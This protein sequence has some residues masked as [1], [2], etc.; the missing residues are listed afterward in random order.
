MLLSPQTSIKVLGFSN[1][2]A[3]TLVKNGVETV[4]DLSNLTVDDLFEMQWMG[5]AG[6]AEI[7]K[8]FQWL[9]EGGETVRSYGF[10]EYWKEIQNDDRDFR[11]LVD[12]YN[13]EDLTLKDLSDRYQISRE[14]VRQI[15]MRGT[16]RLCEAFGNG[17]IDNAIVKTLAEYADNRVEIHMINISDDVFTGAGIAHLVSAFKPSLYKVCRNANV[18]GEWFV[19]TED[20]L[21]ELLDVIFEELRHRSTPLLLSEVEEM[22]SIDSNIIMSIKGIIEK[23]GYITHEKNKVVTGVDR[24]SIIEGYLEKIGRPASISEIVENTILKEGQVRGAL[25]NKSNYVN[26]GKSTYDL[27]WRDYSELSVVDLAMNILTAEGRAL[28]IDVII[29]YICRYKT[30]GEQNIVIELLD[31]PNFYRHD[32]YLLIKGW[33]LDK[34]EKKEHG[35]YFVALEDAVLDIINN[36]DELFDFEKIVDELSKYEDGVVS[37]NPSSIKATLVRLADKSLITRV[38]GARTGCYVR[39]G[40]TSNTGVPG[41]AAIRAKVTLGTFLNANIGKQIEIRYKTKRISSDKYWRTISVR[42]QDAKYVF[43]N[44]L[45]SYGYRIKYLKDRIIE[46]RELSN[47][48]PEKADISLDK[49]DSL[50]DM[51]TSDELI[52]DKSYKNNDLMRIFKVSG[53]GGMRK[54]N[55]TNSLVLIANHRQGN[56]YDDSWSGDCMEYTGMGLYG[57]QSVDYMQNKTLSESNDNGVTLYLFESYKNDDYIYRGVVCLDGDPYFEIQKDELG[58]KRK[59]VKFPLRLLKNRN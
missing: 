10:G 5:K 51:P 58:Q 18:N 8:F 7:G 33:T 44:D 23:D 49:T 30:I 15:I 42:G 35:K 56:P 54:S 17:I 48:I 14:R 26:V 13:D 34:I 4:Q 55:Q 27:A 1:R 39:N 45:N 11:T 19:H 36:S 9:S 16:R 6:R 21:S 20:D 3:N 40:E 2:T 32:D 22:Y 57:D 28:K 52:V 59:V 12:Y 43:T 29:K 41:A 37:M 24:N 31:S 53:Q 25:C 47:N 46:Y 38:G 50:D